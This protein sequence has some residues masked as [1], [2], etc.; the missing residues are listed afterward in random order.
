MA[1]LFTTMSPNIRSAQAT[2]PDVRRKVSGHHQPFADPGSAGS[3]VLLQ[4]QLADLFGALA[5]QTGDRLSELRSPL[6]ALVPHGRRRPLANAVAFADLTDVRR[7]QQV[8]V[9]GNLAQ[10]GTKRPQGADD[11]CQPVAGILPVRI[12]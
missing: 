11:L 10:A 5:A 1:S 7:G 2:A 4:G 9:M 6:I 8:H 12:S 3:L